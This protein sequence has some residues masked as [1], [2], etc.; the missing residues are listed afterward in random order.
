[1]KSLFLQTNNELSSKIRDINISCDSLVVGSSIE[2]LTYSYLNNLPVISCGLIPPLHFECFK[3]TDDLSV[4]GIENKTKTIRTNFSEKTSGLNKLWLWER[5][6]FCLSTAGLC[7]MT[8]K[9]VSLRISENS[10]KASTSNARMAKIHYKNLIVFDDNGIYGLNPSDTPSDL[11]KVYDWFHV[12]SGM[13]HKYDQIEDNIDFVR[14]IIF[15]PS[16]RIAGD[17][18]FKDAVS[19]SYIKKTDLDSFEFSDIN[20]R[21]KTKYMMKQAGIRGARN[22]RDMNDKTKFKYYDVK[23]ENITRQIVPPKNIYKPYDN[24]VFNYDSFNDI[25]EKN[26]LKE[27]YV[28]KIF[29]RTCKS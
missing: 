7:P 27:S 4:F 21:F 1:V 22:G 17:H 6:L 11:Y 23:I 26:P 3:P 2:A 8:D 28:S 14:C 15:Y 10:I 19:V 16:E 25:I 20:A 24:I 5:L 18:D 29:K 13:K 9:S 12:R